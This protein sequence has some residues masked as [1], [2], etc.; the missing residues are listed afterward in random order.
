MLPSPKYTVL[1]TT[2]PLSTS[3]SPHISSQEPTALY[4]MDHTLSPLVHMDLKRDISVHESASQNSSNG[5]DTSLPL[6]ERY[7][8]FTPGLFMGLL[9]SSLLLSILYVAISALGSLQVSYAA[10][11]SMNGPAAHKKQQ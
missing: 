10:F 8:F 9:V 3:A 2:S 1:Y 4:E 6:F 5:T 11:D 7:Q